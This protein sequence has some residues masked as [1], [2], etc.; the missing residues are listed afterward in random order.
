MVLCKFCRKYVEENKL[1]LH[2]IYCE[3]YFIKCNRCGQLYDKNDQESHDEEFHKQEI[4]QFC[5]I[6][7]QDLS[8]HI[9]KERQVLCNYC[10]MEVPLNNYSQ[11]D[12]YCSSKTEICDYCKQYIKKRDLN[13]HQQSCRQQNIYKVQQQ[14]EYKQNS[15]KI[16]EQQKDEM[17]YPQSYQLPNQIQNQD[18]LNLISYPKVFEEAYKNLDVKK[19]IFSSNSKGPIVSQNQ[20]QDQYQNDS[21]HPFKFS[22]NQLQQQQTQ[23]NLYEQQNKKNP[24]I[25]QQKQDAQFRTIQTSQNQYGVNFQQ[26]L[27]QDQYLNKYPLMNPIN[28]Q[29]QNELSPYNKNQSQPNQDQQ[30]EVE[31]QQ[32]IQQDNYKE[33]AV[34]RNTQNNETQNVNNSNDSIIGRILQEQIEA[35]ILQMNYS[36]YIKQKK[37][38]QKFEQQQQQ[39]KQQQQQQI[40][41]PKPNIQNLTNNID[42]EFEYMSQDQ[43]QLQIFMLQMYQNQMD[44]RR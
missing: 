35:D 23:Q 12:I 29:V 11:H 6:P 44:L 8:K 39:Q 7:Y 14:Q 27:I 33:T 17:N 38:Q 28:K 20:S 32:Q 4:C 15:I 10:Q 34:D 40:G 22:Q 30:M 5:H 36:E 25:L 9:C 43:K 3:K 31:F 19:Q 41:H 16:T 2:E 26:N 13:S 18:F 24:N 42:T 21:N 1:Q 37:L